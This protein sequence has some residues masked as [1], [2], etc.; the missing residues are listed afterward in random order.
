[1]IRKLQLFFCALFLFFGI[2]AVPPPTANSM[3]DAEKSSSSNRISG[4]RLSENRCAEKDNSDNDA[5]DQPYDR[6]W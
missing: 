5:Q 1:M 2:K 6:R 4:N 3:K